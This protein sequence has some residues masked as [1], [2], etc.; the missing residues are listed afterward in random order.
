MIL[1]KIGNLDSPKSNFQSI[2]DTCVGIGIIGYNL[3]VCV[4]LRASVCVCVR[5]C[6]CARVYVSDSS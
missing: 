4:C 3:Y 2:S 5:M 6:V 1:I